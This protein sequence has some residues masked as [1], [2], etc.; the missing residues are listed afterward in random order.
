MSKKLDEFA[1]YWHQWSGVNEHVEG[2]IDHARALEQM[3]RKHEFCNEDLWCPECGR[4][5]DK[6]H[7]PDCA[8][9]K[10]LE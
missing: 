10:L 6:G 3:L 8:L 9:A 7:T 5:R 1:T 4:R 2:F